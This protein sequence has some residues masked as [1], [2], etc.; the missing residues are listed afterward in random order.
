[1]SGAK[2]GACQILQ[3]VLGTTSPTVYVWVAVADSSIFQMIATSSFDFDVN[4]DG[5]KK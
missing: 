1:M 3:E 5:L 2:T 4:Y